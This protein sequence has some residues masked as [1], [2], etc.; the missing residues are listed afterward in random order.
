M[1]N[2]LKDLLEIKER[3]VKIEVLLSEKVSQLE[4]RVTNIE[5]NQKWFIRIILSAVILS[6]LSL[7]SLKY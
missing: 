6:V 7:L 5:N 4:K 1:N 3:L 2:E